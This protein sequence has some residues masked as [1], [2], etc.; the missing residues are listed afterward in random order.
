[1]HQV[2]DNL[3]KEAVPVQPVEVVHQGP[4]ILNDTEPVQVLPQHAVEPEVNP[5]VIAPHVLAQHAVEPDVNPTIV[6]PQFS[7]NNV[8]TTDQ[9]PSSSS[10]NPPLVPGIMLLMPR[11]GLNF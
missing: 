8:V 2:V 9:V 1:M 11:A 4:V 5:T 3:I 10:A 7:V 6:A